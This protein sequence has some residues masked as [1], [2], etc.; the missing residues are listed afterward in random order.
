M[1]DDRHG[2]FVWTH[3]EDV[4]MLNNGLPQLSFMCVTFGL[5]H[6]RDREL[7]GKAESRGGF[8][9]SDES[10]GRGRQYPVAAMADISIVAK[11]SLIFKS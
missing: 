7:S 3:N 5:W 11:L 10:G 2:Q 9:E 4:V 1:W 8:R 6:S